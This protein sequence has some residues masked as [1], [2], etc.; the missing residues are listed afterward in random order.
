[1][2]GRGVWEVAFV[3]RKEEKYAHFREQGQAL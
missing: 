3:L 1:M 2:V